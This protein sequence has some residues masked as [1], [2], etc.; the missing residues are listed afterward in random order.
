[1]ASGQ[2][3][4]EKTAAGWSGS[5]SVWTTHRKYIKIAAQYAW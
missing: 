1:M 4:N 2:E 5:I 3:E